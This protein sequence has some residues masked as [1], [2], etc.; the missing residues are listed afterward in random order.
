MKTL[1][2]VAKVGLRDLY[3]ADYHAGRDCD[4]REIEEE[5]RRGENEK[6]QGGHARQEEIELFE[7]SAHLLFLCL[8]R[9]GRGSLDCHGDL[10]SR[11]VEGKAAMIA[12]AGIGRD[13]RVALRAG[14]FFHPLEAT[15]RAEVSL[16]SCAA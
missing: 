15:V 10:W 11:H 9:F 4:G 1:I 6:K 3:S 8:G 2:D 13:R 14:L 12:E 16:I 5:E 7:G